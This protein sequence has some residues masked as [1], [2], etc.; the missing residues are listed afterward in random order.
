MSV[1]FKK[2]S[3]YSPR[4]SIFSLKIS[5]LTPLVTLTFAVILPLLIVGSPMRTTFKKGSTSK[6]TFVMP[7]ISFSIVSSAKG[8]P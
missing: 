1:I 7:D 8:T 3:L 6:R 4:G 2:L 5:L